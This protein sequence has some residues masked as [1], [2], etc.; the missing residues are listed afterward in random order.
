MENKGTHGSCETVT[1]GA[2]NDSG[3]V[4]INKADYDEATHGPVLD[5]SESAPVGDDAAGGGEEVNPND[6]GRDDLEGMTK[7]DLALLLT[8]GDVEFDKNMN[9]AALVELAVVYLGL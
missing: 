3:S 7:A 5:V 8:D 9:K 6:L 2:D 4:I 1:V